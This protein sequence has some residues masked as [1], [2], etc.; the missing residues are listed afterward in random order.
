MDV[1]PGDNKKPPEPEDPENSY[2]LRSF[3]FTSKGEFYA[4]FYLKTKEKNLRTEIAKKDCAENYNLLPKQHYAT[5]YQN[6]NFTL[7]G[8]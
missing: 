2:R 4:A 3:S 1:P 8:C 7:Y 6:R 5:K